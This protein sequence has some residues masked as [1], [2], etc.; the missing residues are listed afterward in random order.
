MEDDKHQ[1]IL[2]DGVIKAQKI[3]CTVSSLIHKDSTHNGASRILYL[4]S[5]ILKTA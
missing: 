5:R 2:C 4:H 1:S 3:I